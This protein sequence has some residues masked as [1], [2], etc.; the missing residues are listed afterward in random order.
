MLVDIFSIW[1][2]FWEILWISPH[3][4]WMRK[5]TDQNNSKYGSFLQSVPQW[6]F[7]RQ[8]EQICSHKYHFLRAYVAIGQSFN[9]WVMY[10]FINKVMTK[11]FI[12]NKKWRLSEILVLDKCLPMLRAMEKL[13]FLSLKTWEYGTTPVFERWNFQMSLIRMLEINFFLTMVK[14]SI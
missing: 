3:S 7:S 13:L 6:L 1:I 5:N 8:V 14:W 9:N 2:D 12:K 4:V 10:P 11:I